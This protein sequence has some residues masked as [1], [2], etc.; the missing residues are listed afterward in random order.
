MPYTTQTQSSKVEAIEAEPRNFIYDFERRNDLE[1]IL[2][3]DKRIS[4]RNTVYK[5]VALPP[6]VYYRIDQQPIHSRTIMLGVVIAFTLDY[7]VANDLGIYFSAR[8]ESVGEC[9]MDYTMFDNPNLPTVIVSGN[10]S[11]ADTL[12]RPVHLPEWDHALIEYE[13]GYTPLQA[14]SGLIL[15]GMDLLDSKRWVI[16]AEPK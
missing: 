12:I 11:R 7:L 10:I 9:N 3:M 1:T 5:Q 2:K 14:L 15:F 16:T 13:L 8:T 4:T 6:D